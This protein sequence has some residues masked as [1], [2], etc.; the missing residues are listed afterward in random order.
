MID[1]TTNTVTATI[2]VGSDPDGV[3][4]DPA[5]DTVYVTNQDGNTVSVIDGATNTVTATIAVGSDPNGVAVDPSTDTVYVANAA[6]TR[7]SV[8]DGATNTVTATVAV[9][10]EPDRRWAWTRHA[11]PSTWPTGPAPTRCR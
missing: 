11:T 5:T 3:A 2:A 9:G 4:V 7:V 8:I 1:G 6:T 10:S